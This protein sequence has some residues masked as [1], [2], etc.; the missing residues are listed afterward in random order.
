MSHFYGT[1]VWAVPEELCF[2]MITLATPGTKGIQKPGV[3]NHATQFIAYALH[4]TIQNL[5]PALGA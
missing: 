5:D 1:P 3:L 2:E 4:L